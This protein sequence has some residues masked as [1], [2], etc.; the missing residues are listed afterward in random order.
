M[1]GAMYRVACVAVLVACGSSGSGGSSPPDA[2]IDAVA[3]APVDLTCKLENVLARDLS[4]V[5]LA[6]CGV[7]AYD[8]PAADRMAMRDCVNAKIASA[9]PFEAV[10]DAQGIDSRVAFAYTGLA[11][12]GGGLALA[13]YH[14]DGSP[15]GQGENDPVTSRWS[16]ASL[17]AAASCDHQA[18]ELSLCLA[19]DQESFVARC[20]AP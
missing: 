12:A 2:M 4:G 9:T 13:S 19:C 6:S 1:I 3:D 5:T 11:A 8:A 16:C 15:E 20:P 10:W 14:Y 17:S 18:L 7:L